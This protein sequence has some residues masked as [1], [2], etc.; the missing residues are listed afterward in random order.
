MI[1]LLPP[2][3][4]EQANYA[5]RNSRLLRYISIGLLVAVL[6]GVLLMGSL[7]YGDH[8]IN[9]LNN[10]LNSRKHTETSYQST[11]KNVKSLE[12]NLSILE[13]LVNAKTHYSVLLADVAGL[14][15]NGAYINSMTL[16]GDDTQPMQ[17]LLTVTSF[18]QAAQV[19]NSFATSERFK[20]ADIQSITQNQDSKTYAVTMVV[21]FQPGK[22]QWKTIIKN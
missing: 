11:E 4:K 1:N 9:N 6:L 18:N 22:A 17:I 12:S 8:Q 15:P 7:W 3:L 2:E 21:A 5:K 19:R 16:T 10:V 20:S 13:K 14:L